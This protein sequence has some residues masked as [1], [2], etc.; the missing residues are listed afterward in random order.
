MTVQPPLQQSADGQ[1][2]VSL[3][4]GLMLSR[5]GAISVNAGLGLTIGLTSSGL[6]D[7][8]L[9]PAPPL[10]FDGQGR[11]TLNTGD[12]LQNNSG[13]IGVNTGRGININTATRAM[14]VVAGKGLEYT[15]TDQGDG[16]ALTVKLGPGLRF[17]PDGGIAVGPSLVQGTLWTTFRPPY[18]LTWESYTAPGAKLYLSLVRTTEGL[19]IGNVAVESTTINGL[20]VDKSSG[21]LTCWIPLTTG[22]ELAAYSSLSGPWVLKDGTALQKSDFLPSSTLYPIETD[23][24]VTVGR[25]Y[26]S[27]TVYFANTLGSMLM[28]IRLN[29]RRSADYP[30]S[31][32]I[33]FWWGQFSLPDRREFTTTSATFT[34][35]T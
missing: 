19:V 10:T 33:H 6:F 16:D 34:Y 22:G 8:R 9:H 14:E 13:S 4:L 27:Q 25:S 1:L 18:N 11:L 5:S 26:I 21:P 15:T 7:V 12:G 28:Q 17:S 20:F 32:G 3:G 24:R 23:T 31:Y 30:A 35:W 2:S 29:T